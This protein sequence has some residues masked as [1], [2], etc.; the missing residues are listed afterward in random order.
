MLQSAITTVNINVRETVAPTVASSQFSFETAPQNVKVVFSEDVGASLSA[1]DFV[2]TNLATNQLVSRTLT[3]AAATNTATLSFPFILSDGDYRMTIAAG[4]VVDA[5]GN[6]L[7]GYNFDFFFLMGDIN[8]DRSVGFPDLVT[9]AQNY[10]T[11]GRTFSG[12]NLD[13]SADGVVAFADLVILAQTYNAF[14]PP[15][16]SASPLSVATGDP[17]AT[18]K[19]KRKVDNQGLV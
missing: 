19:G 17:F 3:Y 2:F 12:G 14:L 4:A 15:L 6:A 1:S 10:N 7:A 5:A 9:L 16:L 11:G 18:G 8:R 13:Y